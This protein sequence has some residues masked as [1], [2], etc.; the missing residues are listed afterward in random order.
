MAEGG[1]ELDHSHHTGVEVDPG[2]AQ[3]HQ[4]ADPQAGPE[5][6][7]PQ[8][9]GSVPFHQS[10]ELARLFGTPVPRDRPLRARTRGAGHPGDRHQAGADGQLERPRQ[11]RPG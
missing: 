7:G 9:P 10:E 2:P 5:Q 3:G 8:W 4:L 11:R 6:E 1:D